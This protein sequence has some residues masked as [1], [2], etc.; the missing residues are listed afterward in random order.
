LDV[1]ERCHGLWL[2]GGELRQIVVNYHRSRTPLG[3]ATQR[4][5]NWVES[6]DVPCDGDLI[7]LI[8][9]GLGELASG[10]VEVSKPILEFLGDALSLLD[11]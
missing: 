6:L 7:Q 8:G 4:K 10:G 3:A 11:W 9:H 5:S 2:D 1:C